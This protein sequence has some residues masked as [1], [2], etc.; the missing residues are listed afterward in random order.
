MQ[1]GFCIFSV[2]DPENASPGRTLTSMVKEV[3]MKKL[4]KGVNSVVTVIAIVFVI[5]M[6]CVVVANIILRYV[7]K[8]PIT[9]ATE[10]T[11]ML[12]CCMLMC[13]A[14]ALL[15]GQHVWIDL[16]TSKFGRKASIVLDLVTISIAA[17]IFG[18]MSVA[19]FQQM[20]R[21]RATR[22]GYTV[23]DI[24]FWPFMC[25]FGIALVIFTIAIVIY[26]IDRMIVYSKGDTPKNAFSAYADEKGIIEDILEKEEPGIP[27]EQTGGD[28]S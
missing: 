5:A 14:P 25:I 11:S 18:F 15:R 1:V 10:I 9:G 27:E 17:G 28:N 2:D 16:V 8:H 26:L 24:P 19:V 23:L 7:F 6:L 3:V 22:K 20:V 21:A 12:M 4:V 13:A